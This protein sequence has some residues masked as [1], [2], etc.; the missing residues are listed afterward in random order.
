MLHLFEDLMVLYSVVNAVFALSSV[1]GPLIGVSKYCKHVF[2][3]GPNTLNYR[4][5]SQIMYHGVGTFISS[6]LSS[7]EFLTPY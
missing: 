6:K 5:V 4:E 1:F 2:N 7:P 3:L